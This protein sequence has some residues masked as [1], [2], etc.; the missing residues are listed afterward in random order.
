MTATAGFVG[1]LVAKK[2]LLPWIVSVLLSCGFSDML[3]KEEDNP[4]ST[5]TLSRIVGNMRLLPPERL[6]EKSS[7]TL[8]LLPLSLFPRAQAL[9]ALPLWSGSTGT[10]REAF[11][12]LAVILHLV[13]TA[14]KV[15]H[16][17]HQH[18]LTTSASYED[19]KQSLR[20]H[21]CLSRP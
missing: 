12:L 15:K 19:P 3:F 16:H 10:R 13:K 7:A 18:G 17:R 11:P 4:A 21:C 20:S 8:H 1:H 2:R 6:G 5:T 14:V 9:S